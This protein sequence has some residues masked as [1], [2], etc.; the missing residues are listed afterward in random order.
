LTAAERQKQIHKLFFDNFSTLSEVIYG[1]YDQLLV[2]D[3]DRILEL[4]RQRLSLYRG[5]LDDGGEAF[6]KWES[7]FLRRE[8]LR[9]KITARIMSENSDIIHAAIHDSLAGYVAEDCS[10][11][12]DDIVAEIR[13]LIFTLAFPLTKPGTSKREGDPPAALSTRIYSLTR[14]HVWF[15][16]I[17]KRE[18][19]LKL[20][21]DGIKQGRGFYVETFS[22]LELNAMKAAE[23]GNAERQA[24]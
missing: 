9:Y 14:K 7:K 8:G 12:H 15:Y 19:R 13:W 5:T 23:N 17:A 2:W 3:H 4:L 16:H 10:V 1:S 20:T 21:Q 18:R 24:A 22:D 11:A 6:V